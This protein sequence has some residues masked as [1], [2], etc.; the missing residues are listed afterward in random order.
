MIDFDYE[1]RKLYD[2]VSREEASIFRSAKIYGQAVE[3]RRRLLAPVS[4]L[5]TALA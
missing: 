2:R 3:K 4:G 1:E 5:L